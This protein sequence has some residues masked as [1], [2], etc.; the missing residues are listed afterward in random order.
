[1]K[2]KFICFIGIDGSGKSTQAR[3]LRDTLSNNGIEFRYVYARFKPLL[4]KPIL[5]AGEFILKENKLGCKT[6]KGYNKRKYKKINLMNKYPYLRNAMYGILLFD[7]YI[8]LLYKIQIPLLAGRNIVCDRY[9]F[10]TIITD[11]SVDVSLSEEESFN[12]I[13]RLLLLLPK[14]DIIF[15][16]DVPEEVAFKRKDDIV[17]I[18]YLKDRRNNYLNLIKYFDIIKLNGTDPIKEL[19]QK[20]TQLSLSKLEAN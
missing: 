3:F 15:M 6:K 17:S 12:I 10:D 11:I 14:P 4:F 16:L 7:Y 13:N 19:Q 1:M 9:I 20:I 5:M 8:Q 2:S 18:G